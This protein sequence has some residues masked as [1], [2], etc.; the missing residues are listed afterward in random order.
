MYQPTSITGLISSLAA[1]REVR[2]QT[3][4][5]SILCVMVVSLCFNAGD[6][7]VKAKNVFYYLT[8]TGAVDL[9]SIQDSQ[10]RK[11]SVCVLCSRCRVTLQYTGSTLIQLSVS[12]CVCSIL[13]S[14][15]YH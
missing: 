6:E 11:V 10:L 15:G 4:T 13:V 14:R 2:A 8:Y 7:A 1:S 3:L 9:E 5:R 12:V